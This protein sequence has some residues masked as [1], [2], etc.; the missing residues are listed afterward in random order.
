MTLSRHLALLMTLAAWLALPVAATPADEVE[1]QSGEP[2]SFALPAAAFAHGF[3]IEVGDADTVLSIDLEAVDHP[4]VDIDLLV[5]R[6]TPFHFDAQAPADADALFDQAQYRS[7][8]SSGDETLTLLKQGRLPLRAGRWYVAALNFVN[9]EVEVRLTATLSQATEAPYV[10]ISVD[11][12]ADITPGED[13]C[14]VAPWN[15][16]TARAPVGGNAGTTLGQQ[17]RNAMLEAARLLSEELRPT[18]PIRLRACWDDLGGGNALTLAQASSTYLFVDDTGIGSHMPFLDDRYTYFS[19]PAAARQAGTSTCHFAGGPC[20]VADVRAQFNTTVDTSEGLG[21]RGFYYGF[22]RNNGS[23]VDFISIGIHEITHGL[24]F[25]GLVSAGPTDDNPD[26]PALG[27]RFSDYA[28]AFDNHVR[29]VASADDAGTP[30]LDLD[31]AD[32]ALA[33]TSVSGLRFAGPHVLTSPRN[34]LAS[35]PAPGNYPPLYAPAN[36]SPGSTLS[37]FSTSVAGQLMGPFSL[38]SAPH[39][40][41]LARDVLFDVGWD[42]AAVTAVDQF[43]RPASGIYFDPARNGHGVNLLR[44]PGLEDY[45]FVV[46]YTFDASGRPEFYTSGG[47]LVDGVF[48]PSRAAN[49]DSL[50]RPV[51]VPGA[52][53]PNQVDNSPG[54]NGQIRIDFNEAASSPACRDGWPGRAMDGHQA[55]MSWTINAE[56]EQ[57]CIQPISPPPPNGEDYSNLWGNLSDAGWGLFTLS[58]PSGAEDTISLVM[59]YPDATGHGRWAIHDISPFAGGNGST[60]LLE[61]Q[62][63]CRTCERPAEPLDQRPVGDISVELVPPAANTGSPPVMSHLDVEIR[64]SD[65]PDADFQRD[66]AI[67]PMIDWGPIESG[68]D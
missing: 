31:A 45:Y 21:S 6:A 63:Y 41:G 22:D 8:S 23:D 4:E 32:R 58:F 49:G 67:F 36:P 64:S 61:I 62:G 9:T 60:G 15:D 35:N 53:P 28:D 38:A 26:A 14:N 68:D 44:V 52:T 24:G 65:M 56:S 34:A 2:V 17:R 66:I 39:T 18:V 37:H 48:V 20:N 57:W 54:F 1:L 55:V 3:F 12:N 51:Y 46:F 27:E 59:Y 7:A 47:P 5:R 43:P 25:F 13:N 29:W 33:M 10:P 30:L 19:T 50:F 42:P 11:F 40:L 16:N